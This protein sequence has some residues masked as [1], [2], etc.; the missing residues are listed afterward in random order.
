MSAD[1]PH[2][3][4][5]LEGAA[6]WL[7][8]NRP[9]HFNALTGEMV[10]DLIGQLRGATTRDDVRVV[11]LTGS[12]G[13]F[14]AGAD[15]G[16]GNAQDNYDAGPVAGATLLTRAITELEKPVVCGL[17]GVAAGVG[18]SAALACD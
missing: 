4:V 2:L 7:T 10:I 13:A 17:N 1:A 14:S 9:E 5:R 3:D 12:G 18:M 16:G 15:L 6:L 8:L 11:V